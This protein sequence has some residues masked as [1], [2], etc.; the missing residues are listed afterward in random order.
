LF[1]HDGLDAPC[2][3][4][5]LDDLLNLADVAKHLLSCNIHV[6]MSRAGTGTGMDVMDVM[7][8]KLKVNNENQP[9]RV[10]IKAKQI[11]S[12]QYLIT[13]LDA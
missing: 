9:S 7:A 12:N 1:P 13:G 2:L 8:W 11:T 10:F 6:E 5:V 4:A 3:K